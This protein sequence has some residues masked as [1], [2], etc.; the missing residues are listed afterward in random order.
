MFRPIFNGLP[1]KMTETWKLAKI[2]IPSL[3]MYSN[4]DDRYLSQLLFKI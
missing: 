4:I 2:E 3:S 1:K